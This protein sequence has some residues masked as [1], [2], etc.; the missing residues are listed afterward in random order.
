MLNGCTGYVVPAGDEE[1][2][3]GRLLELLRNR[4][5]AAAFGRAGRQHVLEHASIERMI[6]G[7]EA[8][9]EALYQ[10]KAAGRG[11]KMPLGPARDVTPDAA[12]GTAVQ[13]NSKAV[14]WDQIGHRA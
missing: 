3:A 7:Y 12:S 9:I 10:R 11:G 6:T 14:G 4:L 1:Q 5:R 8:M 2:L 13:E